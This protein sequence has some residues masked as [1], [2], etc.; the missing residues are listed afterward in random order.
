MTR[1][2]VRWA[3][4]WSGPFW[5]SSSMTKIADLGPVLAVAD[6]LD[7]PAQGQVVAGHAGPRRERAG[8]GA[9]GV[10]FAQAHDHE[11]RAGCRSSR[12]RGTP[13]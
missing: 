12:I 3:S 11:P 7:D 9:G 4:T 1:P 10:V 5:A 8:T 2:T 13:G 6:G